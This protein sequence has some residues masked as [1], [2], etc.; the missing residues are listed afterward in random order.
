MR[1]PA[2]D[3]PRHAD[4]GKSPKREPDFPNLT[5]MEEQDLEYHAEKAVEMGSTPEEAMR[6]AR[7]DH[8]DW[9]PGHI[10][11]RHKRVK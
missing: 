10:E 9:S 11:K 7:E 4:V 3:T 6:H 5:K 2:D 8:D 1:K